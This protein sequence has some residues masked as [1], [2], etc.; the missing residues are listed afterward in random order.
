MYSFIQEKLEPQQQAL[1]TQI[2]GQP[3]GA[4]EQYE[5][6]DK[7]YDAKNYEEAAYWYRKSAEQVYAEAQYNLGYMYENGKVVARDLQEARK[8]YGKATTQ[9]DTDAQNKLKRL[10]GR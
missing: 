4:K 8:W 6:G 10:D 3:T 2:T 7:F 5:L 1:Q 9:G